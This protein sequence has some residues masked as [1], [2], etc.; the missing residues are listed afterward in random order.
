MASAK[1]D[2]PRG[3]LSI[4]QGQNEK[5]AEEAANEKNQPE[6]QEDGPVKAMT[7]EEQVSVSHVT[8]SLMNCSLAGSFHTASMEGLC[9]LHAK[10]GIKRP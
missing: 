10:K 3:I 8:N 9:V 1:A 5:A 7:K 2:M 4:I 6:K